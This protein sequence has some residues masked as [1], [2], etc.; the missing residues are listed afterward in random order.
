VEGFVII[1]CPIVDCFV[2]NSKMKVCFLVGTLGR[3]G[4]ERQLVYMLKALK[5]CG[6]D[7][8]I[9]C[10]TKGESYEEEIRSL[11]VPIEWIG[12]SQNRGL[13]LINVINNLRKN[14]ADILQSS[15]F[16]TNIY[17][18]LAGKIL[19]MPSIGAIR[20]DLLSE[21]RS[22]KYLGQW[23]VSLPQFLIVN[24]KLAYNLAI[25][26][27]ILPQNIEFV[28]NV[29]EPIDIKS[30]Q[31]SIS[32]STIKILFVGRLVKQK[33]PERFIQLATTLIK[34][35]P[36]TPL[37][38]QIAGDG[39]LRNELE[40]LAQN[41]GLSSR[42]LKFLGICSDMSAVYK[43]SDILISTSGH[44]GTSNVIL[45]AMAYGLPVIAT[46]VGGT[47]DIINEKRGIL[48]EFSNED[49][50]VK[51]AST[52]ILD[53]KLRVRLG[54]EGRK[55]VKANHSLEHLQT[56]LTTIYKKLLN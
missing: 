19:K 37:Q 30:K 6:I 47:P 27:G 14:P 36:K 23:Q 24:S 55:Y 29:V 50:L 4:A 51:A 34:K 49:V 35:F 33:R 13:R 32:E 56:Q 42:Q 31:T 25:E 8:R 5:K 53:E 10:L 15:H 16:Y 28:Q 22:H 38:F 17:V 1:L 3:G 43:Q 41:L 2:I 12:K 52:L 46:K 26:R 54:S 48:I 18:G 7:A 40:L 39:I 20:N 9:L 44:E 45:E 21:I 11:G